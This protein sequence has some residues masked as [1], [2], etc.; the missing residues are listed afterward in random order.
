MPLTV[1][2]VREA[3]LA[4]LD[5]HQRDAVRHEARQLL[6]VA[7]AGSGKT[8]VMARRVAWWV[9]VDA[10][11]KDRVVAFTFTEAAAEELK[12]RIRRCLE[13]IA[14]PEEN[15]SLGGMYVGTIHG[16]CLK[17]LRDFAPDEFY[18]YD[19]VDDAGRM[20]LIE[21]GFNGVLALR[22]FQ[23]ATGLGKFGSL[24]L[25]LKGYDLLNEYDRLRV[26]LP[27]TQSPTDVSEEADWCRAATLQTPVGGS[28][29]SR[30]FARSASR[31]YAYLRARRFLDFS[32]VQTEVTRRLDTDT[33]F[34]TRLFRSLSR[35][36][37]DEVQDINPVQYSL[38][39][40]VVGD[41]G[42]LTAVG[43][44]RQA[45]YSF[46][47]G[48]VDLMGKL[49][50]ELTESK[51]G[52]V[53]ELPANYRST[54]RI[55]DLANRWSTT[56]SDSAGMENPAMAHRRDTRTDVSARHIAHVHFEN[57]EQEA[58]WIAD[59]I[60]ALVRVGED[61][62][63]GALHDQGAD[64]RGLTLGDVAILVR[65]STDVRTYQEALEKRG[66]SAVVRG[67]PDLFSQ[68]EVL[69]FL[70]ALGVC[71][72]L[73]EFWGS[74][75]DPRGMPSRIKKVLQVDAK[76]MEI[77]PAAFREL[78]RRGVSV[79]EGTD[80][81]LLRL[82]RAI[83]HRLGSAEPQ[84][85]DTAG[86]RCSSA[87][88]RWLVRA[89][90]PRR[91]F[92]QTI[93]HWLLREAA[94]HSWRPLG[95]RKSV[96]GTLFHI[97]QLSSLIK[98][99]ETAG[100]TPADSLKW[101]VIALLSWGAGAARAS[102]TPLL[103]NPDA[104][105][106]TTIH[107]AKG[108]E[109]AAVFVADIC[110]RRF[111]SNRA[112]RRVPV[113]FCGDVGIDTEHLSDNSNYDNERRLMY[114]AITRAERYLY[115][116]AS[117][118]S[119][120][121]FFRGVGDLVSD[122][123]GQVVEGP[124]DV[125]D[126]LEYHHGVASREDRFAT[127][128]SDLR[129]FLECPQDF[130]LRKVLGFNPTIGQEF[131]YG[132]GLHNLLRVVHENPRRWAEL[133]ADRDTL[134]QEIRTLV[135]RGLFYLRYTVGGPLNNLRNHAIGSIAD[136]VTAYASEL[137]RLDFEPEKEFE[138]F[139]PEENLL[140]SGAIDLVRLDD[141]PRVTIVD[142]KSGDGKDETG[143]GLNR[144]LMKLQLAIYGMAAREELEYAPQQGLIRYV[145]EVDSALRELSVDL[146]EEQL[147]A[148]RQVV[149][150]TGRRI[151]ERDFNHGPTDRVED[152]CKKCD[153]VDICPR[154]EAADSRA[155]HE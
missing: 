152:R 24:D 57:R 65:S 144:E 2:A 38:I 60:G 125:K 1:A 150:E 78:A 85:Q 151:R 47:G 104:V 123:G 79:P 92:P 32:T 126:S 3:L 141:P 137:A 99:I 82:C 90:Q 16:F 54:P 25:F 13:T 91:I 133:S 142:F 100:W 64:S 103:A 10:V 134:L 76:P 108:L 131:G 53:Q 14:A 62:R 121:Q 49:H 94:I 23:T 120:S 98:G 66:I 74:Q 73:E 83:S 51:D 149:L 42:H 46:R 80:E 81:R 75:L 86:L 39:R 15:A 6:I 101:Q 127:N 139:I 116:S 33:S 146:H 43:D 96:D 41:Q 109:F 147:G 117:G 102:E 40:A 71:A 55:I 22:A 129:Y 34:R 143:S 106:V 122:V 135:D 12:F 114:V 56:I 87:C 153:F 18:M 30:A 19:V 107:S 44:H 115:L 28:D 20:S 45:I 145:G 36:V 63:T 48:R 111:P 155:R 5:E 11:P 136:Y 52:Y 128:F 70:G 119:K 130:Y 4:G 72:D 138:T 17:V 50:S 8:E 110:A 59:T 132:R 21:Q 97:G 69:L 35:V 58:T 26:S 154:E 77:V 124:L 148:V 68:P 105:T 67:G 84:P 95:N 113:P 9:G 118:S 61:H 112:R 93:L 140:I 31:Y 88:R 37:V 7:G 89:R 27:G 29:V